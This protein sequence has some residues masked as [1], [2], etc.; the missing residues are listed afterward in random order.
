[1]GTNYQQKAIN[2][3]SALLASSTDSARLNTDHHFTTG[4]AVAMSDSEGPSAVW[5]QSC[6]KEGTRAQ[7]F[8]MPF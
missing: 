4:N 6:G 1:M 3:K 7:L 8:L 2:I 5:K